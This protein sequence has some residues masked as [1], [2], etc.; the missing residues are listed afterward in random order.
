MILK[1][2]IYPLFHSYDIDDI[3]KNIEEY[4]P[5]KK[6]KALTVF[7][8]MITNMLIDKKLNPTET[9]LFIRGKKLKISLVFITQSYFAV[10]KNQTKF[11]ALFFYEN[12]KPMRA[13]NY[14][15]DIDFRDFMNLYKEKYCRTM[16]LQ[17]LMLLL[18]LII[19]YVSE[20]IFSKKY[21]N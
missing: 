16:F 17:G 20:R 8:D 7:D 15:S 13:F 11:Y 3:Y 19:F 6:R 5:N 21:K 10:P 1:L 9:Q 2:F 14:P 18:H 4:N 12:F